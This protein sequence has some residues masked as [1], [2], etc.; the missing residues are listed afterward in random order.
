MLYFL[1][2]TAIVA[3][4]FA[5]LLIAGRLGTIVRIL[6]GWDGLFRLPRRMPPLTDEELDSIETEL[7]PKDDAK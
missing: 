4:L 1:V 6:R 5:L 2:G 7:K 3:A